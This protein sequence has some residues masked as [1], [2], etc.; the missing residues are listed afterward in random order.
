MDESYEG[1]I[2]RWIVLTQEI[3]GAKDI[4]TTDKLVLA[5]ISG[6]EL[7]YASNEATAEFLGLTPR[8]VQAVKQKLVRLG[9]IKVAKDTGRG[10]IYQFNMARL[11]KFC[12]S[13]SQNFVNQT[14]KILS[15]YNKDKN[16]N[17]V[18]L[19]TPTG[20]VTIKI[21]KNQFGA[22][23]KQ[24]SEK[25]AD[26]KKHVIEKSWFTRGTKLII[27]GIKRD[28]TF[29]P[30]K[31]KNTEFPLFEKIISMDDQGFITASATE[32]MEGDE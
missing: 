7:F 23:D 9:Y 20:V 12:Q 18:T 25:D 28:D 19:L 27:T 15:P 13:D 10:K 31:Y 26:G 2:K 32:R 14:S 17:M 8:T 29:V 11:T 22:W 5:H 3:L 21:W 16:K 4:N 30:K 1:D 6:F 24:I